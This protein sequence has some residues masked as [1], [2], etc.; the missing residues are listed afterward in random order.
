[1]NQ[2]G[3]TLKIKKKNYYT[4]LH[5]FFVFKLEPTILQIINNW[6][7]VRIG[8]DVVFFLLRIFRKSFGISLKSSLGF[9]SRW[10]P[11]YCKIQPGCKPTGNY[12]LVCN[13]MKSTTATRKKLQESLPRKKFTSLICTPLIN[14][15]TT[16]H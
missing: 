6:I 13:V 11:D 7:E 8:S 5:I 15:S 3:V 14:Y 9:P 12:N 10:K 2:L 4:C 1:L 16:L